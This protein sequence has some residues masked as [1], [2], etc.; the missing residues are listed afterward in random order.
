MALDSS[1]SLLESLMSSA[2]VELGWSRH[3]FSISS[4]ILC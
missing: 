2:S 3:G 1:S 4:L